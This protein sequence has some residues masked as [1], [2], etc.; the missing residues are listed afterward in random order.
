MPRLMNMTLLGAFVAFTFSAT[1]CGSS[2]KK[3][4]PAPVNT[5]PTMADSEALIG[6]WGDGATRLTFD[7]AKNYSWGETRPCGAPPCPT[8]TATG[9]YML[10]G[11]KLY[12]DPA[13]GKDEVLVYRFGWDPR[14][15][16]VSSNKRGKSW[17]LGFMN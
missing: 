2:E 6:S 12:L 3:A 9:T 14:K 17:S 15:L 10:R 8:T 16:D 4:A 5:T 13:E 11:G 1:A 7:N